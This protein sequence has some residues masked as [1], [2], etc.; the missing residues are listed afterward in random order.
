MSKC[1][2]L[3]KDYTNLLD[4]VFIH[5]ENTVKY[6]QVFLQFNQ[7]DSFSISTQKTQ[8]FNQ[9]RHA[10]LNFING[11]KSIKLV[12]MPNTPYS[13]I[14]LTPYFLNPD[15]NLLIERLGIKITN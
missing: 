5:L 15:L 3:E 7:I 9:Y 6:I 2:L 14:E 12:I 10:V 13:V 11:S 1:G 8:L 4:W